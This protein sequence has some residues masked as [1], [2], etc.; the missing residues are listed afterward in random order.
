MVQKIA[1]KRGM[2]IAKNG[3]V[4]QA[5]HDKLR[6]WHAGQGISTPPQLVRTSV[7]AQNLQKQH[8]LLF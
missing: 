3:Y 1:E 8:L 4:L 6:A 7:K 5:K 2:L